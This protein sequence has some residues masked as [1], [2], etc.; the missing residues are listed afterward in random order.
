M[1]LAQYKNDGTITNDYHE[2]C[3]IF[4]MYYSS[5]LTDDNGKLIH[6]PRRVPIDTNIVDIVFT[7]SNVLKQL[8]N[9]EV[10]SSAGSD[11]IQPIFIRILPTVWRIR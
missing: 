9:L 4:N 2:K 10:N 11:G 6:F 1:A 7:S 5:V 8:K 3:D